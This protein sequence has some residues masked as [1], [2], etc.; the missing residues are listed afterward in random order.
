M[1]QVTSFVFTPTHIAYKLRKQESCKTGNVVM[2]EQLL[3]NVAQ[4]RNMRRKASSD[5]FLFYRTQKLSRR[6]SQTTEA[7]WLCRWLNELS[8]KPKRSCFSFLYCLLEALKQPVCSSS[9]L[10]CV[11]VLP[12]AILK[13]RSLVRHE[14]ACEKGF[15]GSRPLHCKL[16]ISIEFCFALKVMVR[17]LSYL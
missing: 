16:Q 3:M 12:S 17:M 8:V 4:L 6:R 7:C 11:C 13:H 15:V 1:L 9:L 5:V 10:D 2:T 14:L